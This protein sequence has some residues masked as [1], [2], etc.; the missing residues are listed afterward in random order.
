MRNAPLAL[1]SRAYEEAARNC[2]KSNRR[3]TRSVSYE[4]PSY[5]SVCRRF[6]LARPT[7]LAVSFGY[8]VGLT[9]E[10]IIQLPPEHLIEVLELE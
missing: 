7:E 3:V 10:S 8:E 5:V 6:A 2:S 4:A 1:L 9:L